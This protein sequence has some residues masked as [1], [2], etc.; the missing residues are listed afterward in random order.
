MAKKKRK[1]GRP[2]GSKTEKRPTVIERLSPCPAC[3]S[4]ERTAKQKRQVY[5]S[6][7]GERIT[8]YVVQCKDCPQRYTIKSINLSEAQLG[9][10]PG[11]TPE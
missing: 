3:G 4:H 11:R 10:D 7:I 6:A 5:L 8:Y 9:I 1:P 2:E